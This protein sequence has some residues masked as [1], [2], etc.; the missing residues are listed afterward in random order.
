MKFSSHKKLHIFLYEIYILSRDK[1]YIYTQFF[2]LSNR[3]NFVCVCV[4]TRINEL[5]NAEIFDC[6]FLHHKII[7]YNTAFYSICILE[8]D[9]RYYIF[10]PLKLIVI[11]QEKCSSTMKLF[12]MFTYFSQYFLIIYHCL[13]I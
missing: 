4:C 11:I 5:K 12:P 7:P 3:E 2:Y 13:S 6:C 1:I 10:I 9:E 8:Y